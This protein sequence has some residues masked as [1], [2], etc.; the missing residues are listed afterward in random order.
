MGWN[1]LEPQNALAGCAIGGG[2]DRT[3]SDARGL[4]DAGAYWEV[5]GDCANTDAEPDP[6]YEHASSTADQEAGRPGN[7]DSGA[8]NCSAANCSAT[9][10]DADL[11]SPD[12]YASSCDS[13]D[14]GRTQ[15]HGDVWIIRGD[16]G[17]I[18]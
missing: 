11:C 5:G 1:E 9:N 6:S 18:G 12:C 2:L 16:R 4:G 14:D 8:A 15:R 17:C 13:Y 7:C 10:L 3:G